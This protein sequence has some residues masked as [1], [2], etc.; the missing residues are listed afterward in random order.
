M[1][2]ADYENRFFAFL[3][4]F[5]IAFFSAIGWTIFGSFVFDFTKIQLFL[6]FDYFSFFLM[7]IFFIYHVF[8]YFVFK[9]VTVG[10]L[11]FNVRIVDSHVPQ[12]RRLSLF[13]VLLRPLLLSLFPLLL[14]N[15]PFM[16]IKKSQ[17]T[18][19]DE[20]V[21]TTAITLR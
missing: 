21:D 7:F 5:I 18:L 19:F 8:F 17:V 12:K 2:K 20:L 3:T 15:I 9:G 6:F 16:L 14:I 13:K 1:N 10:G 4:D 11:L